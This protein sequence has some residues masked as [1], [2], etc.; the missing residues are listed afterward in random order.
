MKPTIKT[1][2]VAILLLAISCT[3]ENNTIQFTDISSTSELVTNS[4]EPV[5]YTYVKIGTQKWMTKN[6]DVT[7]YRNGDSI[8]CVKSHS[9]WATLKTGAWCWYNNDSASY[10]ATYGKLYNWYAVHRRG[11]APA[12]WH[13][14]SDAE[15][16]TL[17]MFLGGYTVAGGKLKDTGTIE[18][19][20]GLWYK[21]NKGATNETGFTALPGGWRSSKG[22]FDDIG[23][24]GFWRTSTENFKDALSRRMVSYEGNI[25]SSVDSKKNGFS[26]RCVKD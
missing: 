22:I 25:Y 24:F 10:A 1:G 23:R 17:I 12:G 9:E 11:F 6:L 4:D 13:V 7:H 19:G 26:V 20:T 3:K 15:W 14:P 16:D 5:K 8:P 2:V 21:P 18:A